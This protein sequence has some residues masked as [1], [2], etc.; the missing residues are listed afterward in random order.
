MK[1]ANEYVTKVFENNN[2]LPYLQDNWQ[3]DFSFI[4]TPQLTPLVILKSH[5]YPMIFK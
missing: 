2:L 1:K 4:K 5:L 3:Q